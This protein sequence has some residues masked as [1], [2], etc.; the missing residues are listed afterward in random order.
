MARK[1]SLVSKIKWLPYHVCNVK[2]SYLIKK[3]LYIS[4]FSLSLEVQNVKTTCR[5]SWREI[6]FQTL[7]FT[8]G[9]FTTK[10]LFQSADIMLSLRRGHTCPREQLLLQIYHA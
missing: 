5:K 1:A 7:S 9:H 2:W 6:L 4:P 8:F 10:V 3:G